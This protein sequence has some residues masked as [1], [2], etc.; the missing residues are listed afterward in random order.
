MRW[1]DC[2]MLSSGCVLA[3]RCS[4]KVSFGFFL[5]FSVI[6]ILFSVMTQYDFLN[7]GNIKFT[8]IPIFNVTFLNSEKF[9]ITLFWFWSL[10]TEVNFSMVSEACLCPES[11]RSEPWKEGILGTAEWLCDF[12]LVSSLVRADRIQH[13]LQGPQRAEAWS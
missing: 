4:I 11:C 1:A 2:K 8:I 10:E 6:V 13:S 3:H 5:T 9:Y 7:F 12:T